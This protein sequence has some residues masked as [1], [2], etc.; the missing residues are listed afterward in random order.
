[1]SRDWYVRE[2]EWIKPGESEGIRGQQ[3]LF[4]GEVEGGDSESDVE[5]AV[6]DIRFE[7]IGTVKCGV[8]AETIESYYVDELQ[9]DQSADLSE[10]GR[11]MLKDAVKMDNKVHF[12]YNDQYAC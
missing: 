12:H 9:E 7:G 10:E 6:F 11:W 5:T 4:D 1:M 2:D 3:S 8:C